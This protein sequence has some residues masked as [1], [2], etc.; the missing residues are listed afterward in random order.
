MSTFTP[1]VVAPL[2]EWDNT[3]DCIVWLIEQKEALHINK[4]TDLTLRELP[5]HIRGRIW[6]TLEYQSA[7]LDAYIENKG[8]A[9]FT[10]TAEYK[11]VTDPETGEKADGYEVDVTYQL[12]SDPKLRVQS[13]A[14]YTVMGADREEFRVIAEKVE[15]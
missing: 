10:F 8:K 9:R 11:E 6:E 13:Y 14:S 15:A 5:E 2:E 7:T 3:T 1:S 12:F 4:Y